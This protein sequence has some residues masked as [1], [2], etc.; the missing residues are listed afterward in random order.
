VKHIRRR[1]II[2]TQAAIL[3]TGA[4]I[5]SSAAALK[6]N[7]ISTTV[8]AKMHSCT[9]YIHES[10]CAVQSRLLAG[11]KE[12][13]SLGRAIINACKKVDL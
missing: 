3:H 5:V 1:Y 2:I 13:L 9:L 11:P 10:M 8:L 4:E 6:S 12:N 7:C